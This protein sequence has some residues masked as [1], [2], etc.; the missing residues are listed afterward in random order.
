M[1]AIIAMINTAAIT[2]VFDRQRFWFKEPTATLRTRPSDEILLESLSAAFVDGLHFFSNYDDSTIQAGLM[3]LS[4]SD[5]VAGAIMQ[6]RLTFC[7]RS[8]YILSHISM[9]RDVVVRRAIDPSSPLNE[10]CYFYFDSLIEYSG[11]G[12]DVEKTD[13]FFCLHTVLHSLFG[14]HPSL[15]VGIDRVFSRWFPHLLS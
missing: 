12:S 6:N 11:F 2:Y 3:F 7:L 9:F 1:F 10:V 4:S 13:I 15:D 14:L 5:G 8:N